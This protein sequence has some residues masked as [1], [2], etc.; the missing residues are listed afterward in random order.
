MKTNNYDLFSFM[1]NNRGINNSFVNRLITSIKKIGYIESKP[2]TV[3]SNLT[4]IDGQHRFH[5]CKKMGIPVFYEIS[6]NI[7]KNSAIISLNSTQN[8][9]RLK[10]YVDYH[11]SNGLQCYKE[12]QDF[13]NKYKLGIS[14]SIVICHRTGASVQIRKGIEF[15]LN[16]Q[17]HDVAIFINKAFNN[18]P[19][20]KSKHFIDAVTILHKKTTDKNVRKIMNNI[21]AIS[22]QV[23]AYSYLIVFEN[24]LNKHVQKEEN[25]VYLRQN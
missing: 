10:E 24:M 11:A 1:P 21:L 12:L 6:E 15:I 5:A 2:I 8:I 9:W 23:D 22:K 18:I 25:K 16:E 3:D 4:I 14:N 19:F 13:E 17:R 7:D 20:A